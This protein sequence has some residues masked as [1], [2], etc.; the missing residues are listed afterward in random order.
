MTSRRDRA[1]VQKLPKKVTP[2]GTYVNVPAL[3]PQ[4][5]AETWQGTCD[6]KRY[7]AEPTLKTLN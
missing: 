6:S 1:L 4:S 7:R 3:D 5:P 2:N